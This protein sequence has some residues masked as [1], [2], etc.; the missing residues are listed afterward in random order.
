VAHAADPG[1]GDDEGVV[2]VVDGVYVD[3]GALQ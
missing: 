2:G 1:V 3:G